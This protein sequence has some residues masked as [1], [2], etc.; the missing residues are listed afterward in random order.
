MKS[1]R[2]LFSRVQ[3]ALFPVSVSMMP[4]EEEETC[5]VCLISRNISPMCE[6]PNM[7]LCCKVCYVNTVFKEA[8]RYFDNQ[9]NLDGFSE[10]CLQCRV[11]VCST[12]ISERQRNV[13]FAS[14][15]DFSQ[16]RLQSEEGCVVGSD[17]VLLDE[18]GEALTVDNVDEV[19]AVVIKKK[20]SKKRKIDWEPNGGSSSSASSNSSSSSCS[21]RRASVR[22][23][24]SLSAAQRQECDRLYTNLLKKD[25]CSVMELL[26]KLDAMNDVTFERAVN[27]LN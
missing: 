3:K 18:V 20:K 15:V 14:V 4:I 5:C 2:N 12:I 26:S 6:L 16:R 17:H 13:I 8:C 22:S 19:V 24:S 27:A 1:A 9:G 25:P 23:S 7:H 10:L 21:S 11:P